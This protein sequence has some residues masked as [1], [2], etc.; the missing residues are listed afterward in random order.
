[1]KVACTAYV[2][3]ILHSVYYGNTEL[4]VIGDTKVYKEKKT[5]SFNMDQLSGEV[6]EIK[7]QVEDI[8]KD[9]HCKNAGLILLCKARDENGKYVESNPWHNFVT[10]N[11]NGWRPSNEANPRQTL[12]KAKTGYLNTGGPDKDPTVLGLLSAGASVIWTRG[13]KYTKLIGSPES[14]GTV[15]SYSNENF[16]FK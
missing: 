14:K 8:Q 5:F 3:N 6:N 4:D 1:M 9:N 15:V 16:S 11:T 7:L 13:R 12:C 10:S 2:D